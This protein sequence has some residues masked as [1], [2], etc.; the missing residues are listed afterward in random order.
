[1]KLYCIPRFFSFV[2]FVANNLFIL[3]DSK[4]LLTDDVVISI[5]ISFVGTVVDG[6]GPN[7]N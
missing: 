2:I 3:I 1:M 6:R 7:L 5:I 4:F